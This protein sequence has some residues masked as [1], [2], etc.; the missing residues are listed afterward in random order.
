MNIN[1][2]YSSLKRGEDFNS[3]R[4]NNAVNFSDG[5]TY[6]LNYNLDYVS[7]SDSTYN[8]NWLR[9]KGSGFYSFGKLKP[10]FDFL[11]EDKRDIQTGAD[12]LLSTSLKYY[13]IDPYIALVDLYGFKL[14]TKY[15]LRDDY[16][17]LSGIMMKQST[18]TGENFEMAYSGVK[19]VSSTLSLT[20]VNKDYEEAF[21]KE[22]YLNS[23][24][25]LVRSQSRFNFWNP[26]PG[27]FYY[28]VSTRKICKASKSVCKSCRRFGELYLS[29]RFKP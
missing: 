21:K 7:S 26:I 27:D 15:S 13:E 24:T 17:P 23:Q 12:T 28:E 14:T 4:F 11:A 25:V 16:L 3:D 19:Q 6:S 10:G 18:S 5:K 20:V 29:W 22:G 2:A 9:Q 8:S 1:S